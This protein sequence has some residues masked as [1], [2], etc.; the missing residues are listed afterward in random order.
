MQDKTITRRRKPL[1]NLV[2][3]SYKWRTQWL[4]TPPEINPKCY[5]E[6]RMWD[7]HPTYAYTG[8]I[9]YTGLPTYSN[10]KVI[11]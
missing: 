1:T 10:I 3:A 2:S 4:F 9:Y 6:F 8:T 5:L 7:G 11:S